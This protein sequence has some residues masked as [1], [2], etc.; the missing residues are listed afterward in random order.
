MREAFDIMGEHWI[1]TF[2]FVF[3]ISCAIEDICNIFIKNKQEG[4]DN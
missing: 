1:L 4:N 2:F 3:A